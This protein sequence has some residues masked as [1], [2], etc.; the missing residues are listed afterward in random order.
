MALDG[1]TLCFVEVRLRSSLRFGTA[2]ASVDAR[3]RRRM[4]RAAK[5]VLATRRLP[6]FRR[7]RF[8]VLAIDAGLK[9]PRV[10][11]ITDAFHL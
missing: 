11:H 4:A 8:D 6:P 5:E 7:V 1:D 9:P 2:E 3:K 10:R